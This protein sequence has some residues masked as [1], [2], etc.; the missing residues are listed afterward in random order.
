MAY[1]TKRADLL[2]IWGIERWQG[3]RVKIKP[4]K[5]GKKQCQSCPHKYYAYHIYTETSGIIK[6]K[7]LGT[8]D[9]D[10]KPRKSENKRGGLY[11]MPTIK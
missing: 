5:C 9:A 1:F 8:C 3:G 11:K 2:V 4:I 10:G 6:E 7:Y